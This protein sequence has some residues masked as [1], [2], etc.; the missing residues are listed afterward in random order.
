MLRIT[1]VRTG[2]PTDA[3]RARRALAR[4]R[5][6]VPAADTSALRVLLVADVLA[7]A[8]EIGGTPAV[9]AADP[10][11]ELR[12]RADALGIRRAEAGTA[13]A[14]P[15]LHVLA[16]G[17]TVQGDTAPDDT[18]P[19]DTAP[20]DGIRIEVAPVTGTADPALLRMILLAT[21]RREPVDLATADLEGARETLARWRKAVA[22]W[23]TRPSKPVPE[24]VRQE[25]RAAWED[26]LDVP[27]VLEVLRR[28]ESDE[29]I[30]DGARFETYAY[31]DRLL[32]LELTR[33][34][35]SV[36]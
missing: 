15:A 32:G 13:G 24:A 14:G 27:A 1:D 19:D 33:D 36:R 30:P 31:A 10:P 12:V 22:T 4:V 8:L 25:L 2:E 26:D 18:A 23:A 21:P 7:R 35:G 20:D 5:V 6:H 34:I 17:D 9:T 29:G 16:Q 3:V 11:E 28:V